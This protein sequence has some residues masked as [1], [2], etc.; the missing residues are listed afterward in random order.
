M[1]INDK[2]LDEKHSETS[3]TYTELLENIDDTKNL[4]LNTGDIDMDEKPSTSG[5]KNPKNFNP[6][7]YNANYEQYDRV[8][9]YMG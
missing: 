6:K 2:D 8:K 7:Y 3:K 4:E 5:V 1:K 9:N